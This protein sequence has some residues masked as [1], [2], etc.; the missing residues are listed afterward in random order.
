MINWS[1]W[2]KSL[3]K[4]E[5]TVVEVVKE[6]EEQEPEVE[7]EVEEEDKIEIKV[8]G[9]YKIEYVYRVEPQDSCVGHRIHYIYDHKIVL[10]PKLTVEFNI[11]GN[12]YLIHIKPD[13]NLI[14]LYSNFTE[15][16]VLSG[17]LRLSKPVKELKIMSKLKTKVI[18]D[19]KKHFQN[20][21]VEEMKKILK[22]DSKIDVKFSFEVKER[23]IK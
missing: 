16:A 9:D 3:F 15:E 18:T 14:V 2:W 19:I 1:K 12:N 6:E 5:E 21:D 20:M 10:S 4:E 22:E 23:E 13:D 17:Y 11:D 8:E 7:E